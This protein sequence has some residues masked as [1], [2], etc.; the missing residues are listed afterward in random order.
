[1]RGDKDDSVN[2]VVFLLL[3]MVVSLVLWM[4]EVLAKG[5]IIVEIEF[6]DRVN[7][8]GSVWYVVLL[9]CVENVFYGYRVDGLY[10]FE[11]GYRFDCSKVL[12]DSYVKATVS[13]F[14]YGELGKKAD[15][16]EDCWL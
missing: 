3:V 16:S 4:F 6:D 13:R 15:G 10:E 11:K 5:E 2:F 7:K 1:M 9:K 12:F 14:R 8:I